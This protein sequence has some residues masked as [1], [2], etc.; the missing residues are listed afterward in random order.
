MTRAMG[1]KGA[2]FAEFD[3]TRDG[4]VRRLKLVRDPAYTL[5]V[6]IFIPHG[7]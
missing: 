7:P 4:P 2:A 1:V 3:E 6:S 5:L